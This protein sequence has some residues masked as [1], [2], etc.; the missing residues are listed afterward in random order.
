MLF[1]GESEMI[2][3]FGPCLFASDC[4]NEQGEKLLERVKDYVHGAV[5]A[6]VNEHWDDVDQKNVSNTFFSVGSLFGRLRA[7]YWGDT[8][9]DPIWRFYCTHHGY[10][11]SDFETPGSI[12]PDISK[13]AWDSARKELGRILCQTLIDHKFY[14][15]IKTKESPKHENPNTYRWIGVTEI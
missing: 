5:D 1:Y 10:S 7:H 4:K 9:L 14:R 15:F 13:A 8:P 2:R 12:P 11:G 3:A 6:W